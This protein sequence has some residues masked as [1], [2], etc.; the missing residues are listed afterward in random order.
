MQVRNITKCMIAVVVLAIGLILIPLYTTGSATRHSIWSI[1]SQNDGDLRVS[2][3]VQISDPNRL[4]LAHYA[5]HLAWLS[6]FKGIPR[7]TNRHSNA[8]TNHYTVGYWLSGSEDELS[9]MLA[10]L[11]RVFDPIVIPKDYADEERDIVLREYDFRITGNLNAQAEIKIDTFLYEGNTISA[12]VIGTPQDINTFDYE[13]AKLLH[14]ATHRPEN[15]TIVVVGDVSERRVQRVLRKLNLPKQLGSERETSAPQ[16]ELAKSGQKTF[17]YKDDSAAPRMIW[18]RVVTLDD[19]TQFDLLEAHTALLSDILSTSL[20]GGLAGPL[21]YDAAIAR[22]F[23]IHVWPLDEDNIEISIA[24]EP[25]QDISLQE[26]RRKFEDTLASIGASGIPVG[27][28]TRVLKRFESYW[29]R[30]NDENETAEWMADYVLD[31]LSHRREPL[32]EREI[33][34]LQNQISHEQINSLLRALTGSART[35]TAFIDSQEIPE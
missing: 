11:S 6:A 25:D 2:Y 22:G 12:S 17:Q 15:T 31:R 34:K 18:R 5:E 14:A 20:P 16:F 23:D 27:T 33:K 32:S 28:Y 8:W 10:R 9:E 4:P 21:R 7:G 19:S 13:E 30:W 29:P 3:I 35:A 1:P 24:A 26:L